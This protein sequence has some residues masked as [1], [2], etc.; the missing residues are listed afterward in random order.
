MLVTFI[1]PMNRCIFYICTYHPH[2][3]TYVQLNS[4]TNTPPPFKQAKLFK[5]TIDYDGDDKIHFRPHPYNHILTLDSSLNP[6]DE[7]F[8]LITLMTILVP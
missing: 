7:P 1:F 5:L 4:K 6:L 3:G 8:I 2:N